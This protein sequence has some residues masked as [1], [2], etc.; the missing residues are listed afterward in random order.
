M[1]K[2]MK[3]ALFI[4][5]TMLSTAALSNANPITKGQL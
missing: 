1:N 3:K 4:A 5:F 2:Q